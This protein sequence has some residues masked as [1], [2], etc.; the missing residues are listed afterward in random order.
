MAFDIYTEFSPGGFDTLVVLAFRKF[1]DR[2][3]LN[4]EIS[5]RNIVD[6]LLQDVKR[7]DDFIHTHHVAVE[8]ISMVVSD[9]FE[10]DF[11]VYPVRMNFT[12]IAF[13]A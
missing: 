1:D 5:L 9:F 8:C 11:I 6:Q 12:D 4:G 3:G 7:F 2:F 10:I 13:P